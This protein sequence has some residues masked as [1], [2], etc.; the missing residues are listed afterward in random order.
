M[1]ADLFYYETLMDKNLKTLEDT[2][3]ALSND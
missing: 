2:L 1:N 3:G